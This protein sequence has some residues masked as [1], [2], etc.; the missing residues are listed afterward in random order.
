MFQAPGVVTYASLHGNHGEEVLAGHADS[1]GRCGH[2]VFGLT[3]I[4]TSAKPCSQPTL[5]AVGNNLTWRCVW[6]DWPSPC[7]GR[8]W[9]HQNYCRWQVKSASRAPDRQTTVTR[10]RLR[11]AAAHSPD[12][13]SSAKEYCRAR[14][15]GFPR[16]QPRAPL[17]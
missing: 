2:V 3:D 16:L 12:G 6:P 8:P 1:G 7:G 10:Q 17:K 9:P 5:K 15:H 11:A 13:K 14:R 4:P